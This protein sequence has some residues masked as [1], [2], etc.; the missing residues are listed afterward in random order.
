MTS[1]QN[2]DI[3][4]NHVQGV[5]TYK[6]RAWYKAYARIESD[7][8]RIGNLV[9]PKTDLGD[10]IIE[11]TGEITVY[12]GQSVVLKPGFHAQNGSTFHAYIKRDCAQPPINVP[13]YGYYH[14]PQPTP[15]DESILAEKSDQSIVQDNINEIGF[16]TEIKTIS[17][18]ELT[19]LLN[20]N[21][22][23]IPDQEEMQTWFVIR[24]DD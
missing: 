8:Y 3:G 20:E 1:N 11:K 10:Y 9:T 12:A 14:E 5:P 19:S 13:V 7:S 15:F 6:Y 16:S 24:N 2:R 22:P 4:L 23:R 21:E 18:R 17:R